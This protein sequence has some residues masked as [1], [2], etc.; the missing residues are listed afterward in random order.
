MSRQGGLAGFIISEFIGLWLCRLRREK[1]TGKTFKCTHA[2]D[3]FLILQ[4]SLT[5]IKGYGIIKTVV[6]LIACFLKF[7]VFKNKEKG[8]GV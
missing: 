7:L 3:S 1:S 5:K 8:F 4:S 2:G 6:F